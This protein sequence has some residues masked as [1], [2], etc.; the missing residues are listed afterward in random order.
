MSENRDRNRVL[1]HI[2]DDD[3]IEMTRQLVKIPSPTGEEDKIAKHLKRT[4]AG[5][6]FEAVLEDVEENRP[7][8][9]ATCKSGKSGPRLLL[10]GQPDVGAPVAQGDD[11]GRCIAKTGAGR[12]MGCIGICDRRG[13]L[14]QDSDN[15]IADIF[16]SNGNKLPGLGMEPGW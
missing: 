3:I 9:V 4:L 10:T 5:M 15:F 13:M 11:E 1:S 7:N 2:N 6:G 8:V 16:S 14:V 12:I